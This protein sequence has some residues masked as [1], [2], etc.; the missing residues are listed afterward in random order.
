[1]PVTPSPVLFVGAAMFFIGALV[2]FAVL[3]KN[4]GLAFGMASL[5]NL[6]K[7]M[8]DKDRRGARRALLGALV[9]SASGGVVTCG[10]VA[11]MDAQKNRPCK[12]TCISKGYK[13]GRFRADPHRPVSKTKHYQCWCQGEQGWSPKP[14]ELP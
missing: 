3:A 14:M 6:S 4:G 1:M 5:H 8:A 2:A 12:E 11:M 10:S 9:L 7:L 13:L